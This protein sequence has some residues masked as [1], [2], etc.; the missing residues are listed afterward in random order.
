MA[1]IQRRL[2]KTNAYDTTHVCELFARF[3]TPPG[4]FVL[5]C[6]VRAVKAP[7]T[8]AGIFPFFAFLF[9]F[10]EISNA[11]T[12]LIDIENGKPFQPIRGRDG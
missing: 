9:S 7:P 2:T 6:R 1:I 8:N 11:R 5:V 12:F 4:P 10:R 3:A